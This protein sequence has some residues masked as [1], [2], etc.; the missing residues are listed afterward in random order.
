[1]LPNGTIR[2]AGRYP[3]REL[4]ELDRAILEEHGISAFVAADD[5]GGVTAWMTPVQGAL[6]LVAEDESARA[7]RIL[8]ERTRDA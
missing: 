3:S 1:M 6:L 8:A 4:A 5:C 2:E 7:Q